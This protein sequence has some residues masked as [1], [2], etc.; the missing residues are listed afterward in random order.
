MGLE[1]EFFLIT[2]DEYEEMLY[3]EYILSS[4]G[5][6]NGVLIHDNIV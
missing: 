2:H 3:G 5:L 6:S 4:D 1:H